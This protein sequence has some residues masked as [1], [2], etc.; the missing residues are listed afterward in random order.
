MWTRSSKLSQHLNVVTLILYWFPYNLTFFSTPLPRLMAIG[1]WTLLGCQSKPHYSD[2][3]MSAMA[4]K[5]TGVSTVC[6][7]ICS[8]ADQRK[9][10]SSA[11]LAFVRG[12]HR[13]PVN[14]PHKEP[15]TWKMHD[16]VTMLQM[17]CYDCGM[18]DIGLASALPTVTATWCHSVSSGPYKTHMCS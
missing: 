4:S 14:S 2:V 10:Q 8:G 1:I 11:S 15:V 12:I 16:D 3:I 17:Y 18:E 9:H 5:I 7:T 13:W 6:S